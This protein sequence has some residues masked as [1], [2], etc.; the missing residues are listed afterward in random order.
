MPGFDFEGG[1][2]DWSELKEESGYEYRTVLYAGGSPPEKTKDGWVRVAYFGVNPEPEL[3][4]E[5]GSPVGHLYIGEDNL[6]VVYR[7]PEE[8]YEDNPSEECLGSVSEGTL[9]PEDLIPKFIG[10]LDDRLEASM[11]E[12]GADAPERVQQLDKVQTELGAIERRKNRTGYYETED[13]GYDLEWLFEQLE[14]YAP[15][16]CTFGAHPG[17][18]ADFG[19]WPAEEEA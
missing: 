16:G 4:D 12:E 1:V 3:Y 7:K 2:P 19:F 10:A 15:E 8:E 18:A 9:L 11:L 5:S 13:S 14:E 6:E 17:D